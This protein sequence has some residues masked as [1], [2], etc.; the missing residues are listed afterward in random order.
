MFR[1]NLLG[2][3]V[4]TV[5]L[6]SLSACSSM[7]DKSA[8]TSGNVS[9]KV[10]G[11]QEDGAYVAKVERVARARGIM[12]TWVNPPKKHAQPQQSN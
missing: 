11:M 1:S 12:L 7:Q 8:S 2:L 5:A 9:S 4:V 6:G 3:A 10:V